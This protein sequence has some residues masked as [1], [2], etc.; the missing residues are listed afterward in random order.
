PMDPAADLF[1][2]VGLLLIGTVAMAL[3]GLDTGTAFGGMGASRGMTIAALVEPTLL[4]ALFALSV[5]AGSTNLGAIV[6]VGAADPWRVLTPSAA[7][8]LAALVVAILAESGRLPVD[9]PA[10]H[11]E[12]TMIHEAMA[13]EYAG[14]RLALLEWASG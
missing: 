9:N 1:A 8:A 11:L 3:A 5:P 14:P 2:V 12:L 4:L 10:T 13:L 7:L 6:A